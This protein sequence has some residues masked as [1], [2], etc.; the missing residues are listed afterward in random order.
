MFRNIRSLPIPCELKIDMQA[1]DVHV[2][3][4]SELDQLLLRVRY[5]LDIL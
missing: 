4:A 5:E 2:T 3:D 1:L